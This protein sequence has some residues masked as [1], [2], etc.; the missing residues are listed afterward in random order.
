[1]QLGFGIIIFILVDIQKYFIKIN[2]DLKENNESLDKY[3]I[4]RNFL[5]II[6]EMI[7]TIKFDFFSKLIS[8]YKA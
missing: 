7:P 2:N 3:N 4:I 6:Q 1:M 5:K 8:N